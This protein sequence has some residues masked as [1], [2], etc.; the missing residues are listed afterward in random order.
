MGDIRVF[1]GQDRDQL[2]VGQRA[3]RRRHPG[4]ALPA[5]ALVAQFEREPGQYAG[6][7]DAD[8]G[9][10]TLL[11]GPLDRV[12]DPGAP[13]VT[14]L[15]LR[16]EIDDLFVEPEYR[17]RGVGTWLSCQA[18]AWRRLGRSGRILAVWADEEGAGALAFIS[19]FGRR[20]IGR[21]RRGWRSAVVDSRPIHRGKEDRRGSH[22]EL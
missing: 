1:T 20:E 4:G 12:P 22:P 13:P 2:L 7:S 18:V 6:F 11:A 5:S 15:V 10:E 3:H 8:G 19:R 16:R 17:R 9:T 21:T 14:G